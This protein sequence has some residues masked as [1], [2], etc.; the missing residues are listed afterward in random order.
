GF[1]PWGEFLISLLSDAPSAQGHV[2]AL[3][4]E[5]R[6]EEAAQLVEDTLGADVFFEELESKC[7]RDDY[8]VKGPVRLLPHLFYDGVLTTNFDQVLSIC[9]REEGREFHEVYYGDE[10]DVAC[11]ELGDQPHCLIKLHGDARRR[12][13]RVL[14]VRDDEANYGSGRLSGFLERMVGTRSVL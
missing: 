5:Q 13:G 11:R 4:V 6:F 2:S 1:K 7:G 10:L 12:Q 14:T 9:Y 8:Q 3:V